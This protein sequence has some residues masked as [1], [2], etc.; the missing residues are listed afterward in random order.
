MLAE[1]LDPL[2][3]ERGRDIDQEGLRVYGRLNINTATAEALKCLPWPRDIKIRGIDNPLATDPDEMKLLVEQIMAYRD[4]RPMAGLPISYDARLRDYSTRAKVPSPGGTIGT[5]VTDLR[6]NAA[7]D[8]PGFLT[9][10]EIAIPLIDYFHGL[11]GWTDYGS[12]TSPQA[13]A[14]N[15]HE[16]YHA[17]RLQL[18]HRVA[19]LVTVNSDTYSVNIVVKLKDPTRPFSE[20]WIHEWRY[21]AVLDRS[22]CTN[23]DTKPAVLLFT[24]VK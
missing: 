8:V 1:F 19:N 20:Q 22:N 5:L 10:G 12:K 15:S 9:P 14:V 6:I 13:V 23:K 7:S 21:V 17:E 16:D 24:R 3:G 11:A 18:Y 2:K 4:K